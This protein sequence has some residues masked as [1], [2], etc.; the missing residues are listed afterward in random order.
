MKL[1]GKTCLLLYNSSN[2]SP[3]EEAKNADFDSTLN[4]RQ[5][6]KAVKQALKDLSI[7]VQT[8]GFRG[9]TAKVSSHFESTKPDFVFNL[10]ETLYN[11]RHKALSEMYVAGWL[12]LLKIPYTGSPP[13]S[14][15]LALNKMRC[16]QI[17]RAGGLPVP[18]SVAVPVGEKPNLES[19]TPPFIIKPVR[20][21]GSFGITK[22]SVVQTP[23]EA[24]A[25]VN[26]IH[27]EYQQS[28]LVEEFIGG[29]ELT[30]AVIDNP[31]RV[32]GIGEMDFN[33]LPSEEPKIISYRTK[34]AKAGP[35]LYD[36]PA[37]I[38]PHLK[39]RLEKMSLK[40][41]EL[42]GCQDYAR[43][44]FRV[45]ENRRPY[46]LEVN[47]NPDLSPEEEFGKSAKALGLTYT[48]LVEN[49]VE[50]ALRRGTRVYFD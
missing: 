26:L 31:P 16:K 43:I 33:G 19:I 41:F 7:N 24:E 2:G 45:S 29:R 38:E 49:I 46:I 17:L 25:Q 12:E 44:D 50:S 9:L 15:G 1:A 32:F 11:H 42:L 30:V 8:L 35:E 21:D 48:N 10:C 34:W 27:K 22:Y 36:F 23:D 3:P 14:L 6:V 13:L 47:P 5:D 18:P 28:A 20:E 4:L 40:A 37:Q 39:K